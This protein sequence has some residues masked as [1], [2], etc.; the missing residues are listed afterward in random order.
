M[1]TRLKL[2]GQRVASQV[3]A[4]ADC[5]LAR[6]GRGIQ[7]GEDVELEEAGQCDDD[8]VDDQKDETQAGRQAP[9]VDGNGDEQEDDCGEKC[10]RRVQQ[11]RA[12]DGHVVARVDRGC[13]DEPGQAQADEDVEHIAADGVGDRHVAKPCRQEIETSQVS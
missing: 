1:F 5:R 4:E 2:W 10:E 6:T 12:V 11:A 7:V 13:L 8:G 9:F 3:A